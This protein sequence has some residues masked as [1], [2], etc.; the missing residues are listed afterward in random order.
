MDA[1]RPNG[2]E[3]WTAVINAVAALVLALAALVAAVSG[4]GGP[5]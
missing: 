5:A 4:C 2:W 1:G 3:R